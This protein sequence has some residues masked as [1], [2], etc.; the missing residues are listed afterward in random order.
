MIQM[1]KIS[2]IW[3]SWLQ[4]QHPTHH[5]FIIFD[6]ITWPTHCRFS[7]QGRPHSDS[8]LCR[9]QRPLVPLLLLGPPFFRLFHLVNRDDRQLL[10]PCNGLWLLSHMA[11]SLKENN[12]FF[13]TDQTPHPYPTRSL[14]AQ[15]NDWLQFPSSDGICT[16][17]CV[18]WRCHTCLALKAVAGKMLFRTDK[19]FKEKYFSLTFP[20]RFPVK[21]VPENIILDF[22]ILNTKWPHNSAHC[23]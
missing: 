2:P 9:V 14:P 16:R 20:W 23:H 22:E 21:K 19:F 5:M 13:V 15:F 10:A 4:W 17:V 6:Q 18:K 8:F 1:A 11:V 7:C 3:S 12:W